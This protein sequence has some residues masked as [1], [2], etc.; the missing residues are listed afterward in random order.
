MSFIQV[1]KLK[2]PQ[3]LQLHKTK[4]QNLLS[5]IN[6]N[7]GVNNSISRQK[8]IFFPFINNPFS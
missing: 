1:R 5:S 3:K 8:H 4:V 2:I 7:N 6:I